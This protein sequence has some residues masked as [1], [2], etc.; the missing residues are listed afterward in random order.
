VKTA[1]SNPLESRGV[2]E[3]AFSPCLRGYVYT[4]CND[5]FNKNNVDNQA[6]PNDGS[7]CWTVSQFMSQ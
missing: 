2:P 1:D 4:D 7:F 3:S 6:V 5:P